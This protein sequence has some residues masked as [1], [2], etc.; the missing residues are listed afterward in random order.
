MTIKKL[1]SALTLLSV[2]LETIGT[3]SLGRE[4]M[5]LANALVD[6]SF[7]LKDD[8]VLIYDPLDRDPFISTGN[9]A[10]YRTENVDDSIYI[11]VS[12]DLKNIMDKNNLTF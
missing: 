10:L 7:S 1:M 12:E 3:R 11:F 4:C 2:K 5:E 6:D 9:F 8:V